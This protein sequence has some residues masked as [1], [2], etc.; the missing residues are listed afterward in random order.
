[1][2]I[3]ISVKLSEGTSAVDAFLDGASADVHMGVSGNAGILLVLGQIARVE[4]NRDL[5]RGEQIL[6]CPGY[7]SEF[8]F[9]CNLSIYR[10]VHDHEY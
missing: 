9:V 4:G 1:M 7:A 6:E 8:Q 5:R 10:L 2:D 3:S